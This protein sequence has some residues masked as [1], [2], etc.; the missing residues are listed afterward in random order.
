M[1][2][3]VRQPVGDCKTYA[4]NKLSN[5]SVTIAGLRTMFEVKLFFPVWILCIKL[6]CAIA[7]CTLCY[8]CFTL[9]K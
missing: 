3:A 4:T 1:Y 8:S 2:N 7:N 9:Y 6:E 5:L